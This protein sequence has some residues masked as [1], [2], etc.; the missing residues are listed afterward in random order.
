[1]KNKNPSI[2]KPEELVIIDES[3]L[4]GA[5]LSI[6]DLASVESKEIRWVL[7]SRNEKDLEIE[8]IVA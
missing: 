1:M 5:A 8:P 3:L 4:G 2:R 7:I 6:S